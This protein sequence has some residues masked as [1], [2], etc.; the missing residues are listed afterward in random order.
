[1]NNFFSF[2]LCRT[3]K[4]CQFQSI[5][6]IF[7]CHYVAV[8]LFFFDGINRSKIRLRC[9]ERWSW[10]LFLCSTFFFHLSLSLSIEHPKK[11]ASTLPIYLHNYVIVILLHK[12]PVYQYSLRS[13]VVA[14]CEVSLQML[15]TKHVW[16]CLLSFTIAIRWRMQKR[17]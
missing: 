5:R 16:K 13:F 8:R 15:E 11:L 1:L 4:V 6:N 3:W 12:R 17:N 9:K 14:C 7:Q 10:K 2:S